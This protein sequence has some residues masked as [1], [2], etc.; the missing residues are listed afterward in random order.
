MD[1]RHFLAL[2]GSSAAILTLP[3]ESRAALAAYT[4]KVINDTGDTIRVKIVGHQPNV[5]FWPGTDGTMFVGDTDKGNLLEG[6]RAIIVWK[7]NASKILAMAEVDISAPVTVRISKDSSG[8]V[9]VNAS[10]GRIE[11]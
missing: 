6:K 2:C 7:N 9:V 4:C 1:R 10:Y 11:E 5:E 8:S 3:G